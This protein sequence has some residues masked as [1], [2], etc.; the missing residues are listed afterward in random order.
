VIINARNLSKTILENSLDLVTPEFDHLFFRII[1]VF[2]GLEK[3]LEDLRDV[4][5]VELIVNETRSWQE[6]LLHKVKNV[7]SSCRKLVIKDF[8]VFVEAIKFE[9]TNHFVNPSHH[10]FSGECEVKHMEV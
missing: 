7:N 10:I 2:V 1:E 3:S 4:S 8:D 6:L 9:F 5:H